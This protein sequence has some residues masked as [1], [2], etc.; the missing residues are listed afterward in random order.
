MMMSLMLSLHDASDDVDGDD[1]KE[2][3]DREISTNRKMD[4]TFVAG[5]GMVQRCLLTFSTCRHWIPA[6]MQCTFV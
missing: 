5:L 6:P 2:W 4:E 1:G 3:D